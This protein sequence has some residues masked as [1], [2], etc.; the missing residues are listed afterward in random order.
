MLCLCFGFGF[1]AGAT[2]LLGGNTIYTMAL[3]VPLALVVLATC[4][5]DANA[6]AT[7]HD[8]RDSISLASTTEE[9]QEDE[10]KRRLSV[11]FS[12]L[13]RAPQLPTTAV[14]LV[15]ERERSFCCVNSCCGLC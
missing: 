15:S 8:G 10:K 7:R 12:A 1:G 4:R 14:S 3:F 2:V 6:A 5:D 13:C 9:R 11:A